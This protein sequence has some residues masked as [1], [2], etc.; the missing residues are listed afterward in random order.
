MPNARLLRTDR[1]GVSAA[2]NLGMRESGA[3][4]IAYIDDDA[5]AA[6]DWLACM[7]EVIAM[8]NPW[9]GVIGG[10]VLPVWEAPLPKWW[11]DSLR[12]VLSIIEWEGRGEFR[13]P[14]TPPDLEPYGVNMVV[15]RQ[16]LL[17]MGGFADRLGRFGGLLLSDEDVQVGWKMQDRGY[18]AW[19]DSRIV[20]RHQIQAGRMRV[21]WLLD[22]LYWQGAST[23]ATRRIL[24]APDQV[25]RE[26][27]R[28]LTVELITLPFALLP[29]DSTVLL[30]LRW[31]L[32]YA[33]GFTRMALMGEQKKRTLPAR[34]LR[35]LLRRG[36]EPVI[37]TLDIGARAEEAG[38]TPR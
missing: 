29:R 15:Q 28:R 8:Y 5:L 23:V 13:T 24:G 4:F 7:R 30:G 37:P 33:R 2:R 38:K 32:A 12:G 6:P 27:P 26:L 17:D 31:R 19:Y 1:P 25:W 11:P 18:S 14:E 21:E 35:A 10:R 20:V 16:P 3:D 9:P 34:L 22:R 36:A